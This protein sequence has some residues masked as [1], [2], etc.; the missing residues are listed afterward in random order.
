MYLVPGERIL[1]TGKPNVDEYCEPHRRRRLVAAVLLLPILAWQI[2][3]ALLTLSP[4]SVVICVAIAIVLVLVFAQPDDS[5]KKAAHTRY[6]VTTM[7]V[8]I[9]YRET[10][11][12]SHHRM[13]RV[14]IK[15]EDL[16]PGLKMGRRD[17]GSIPLGFRGWSIEHVDG[18]RE[19]FQILILETLSG[20]TRPRSYYTP[21]HDKTAPPLRLEETVIWSGRPDLPAYVLSETIQWVLWPPIGFFAAA[22]IIAGR[23]PAITPVLILFG[24]FCAFGLTLVVVLGA[25]RAAGLRY[26]VTNERVL[27]H[28]PWVGPRWMERELSETM[29]TKVYRRLRGTG[30]IVFDKC[31]E[32]Y[33]I[34]HLSV[35]LT[36]EVTFHAVPDYQNVAGIVAAAR[37]GL[38]Q[39][40]VQS[41]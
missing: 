26:I 4:V 32:D 3:A 19:L 30:T 14:D 25:L 41:P 31:K 23:T 13:A 28:R 12:V 38:V 24:Q 5:A 8:V 6:T 15:A 7:R 39:R 17:C 21:G 9:E 29:N 37:N 1:W 27:V 20:A 10:V 33:Q 36:T 22:V 2:V 11:L 40:S 34:S 35:A 18:A 16:Q